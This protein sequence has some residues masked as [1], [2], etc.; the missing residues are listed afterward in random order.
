MSCCYTFRMFITIITKAWHWTYPKAVSPVD[1]FTTNFH[2]IQFNIIFLS[3][4]RSP[5]QTL[6][7]RWATKTLNT[8]CEIWGY[9]G[10]DDDVLGFD[11]NI[12]EKYTVSIYR[13]EVVMLESGGSRL[14]PRT[15]HP[16]VG[17]EKGISF[18]LSLS[19]STQPAPSRHLLGDSLLART[20]FLPCLWLAHSLSLPFLW[21]YINPSTSQHHT[22]ALKMERVC[23][24]ET[25]AFTYKSAWCQ[26]TKEHHH[27]HLYPFIFSP[28]Y[29]VCRPAWFNHLNNTVFYSEKL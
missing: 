13:A 24:S 5:K 28:L 3:T 17:P 26:N 10:E 29:S 14:S 2:K 11:A 22:S 16:L 23:F 19:L 20:I 4:L 8:F 25:L 27:H 6:L 1:I 12:L 21:P 7:L 15:W 9:H 18:S